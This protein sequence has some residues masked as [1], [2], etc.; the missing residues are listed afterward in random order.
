MYIALRK[1][2]ILRKFISFGIFSCRLQQGSLLSLMN[3]PNIHF[4][5]TSVPHHGREYPEY[6]GKSPKVAVKW[7]SLPDC[8]ITAMVFRSCFGVMSCAVTPH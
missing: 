5:W 1:S 7:Q 2:Q 6:L 3:I 8:Y 4:I